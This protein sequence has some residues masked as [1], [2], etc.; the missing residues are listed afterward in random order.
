[1]FPVSV[2]ISSPSLINLMHATMKST[3]NTNNKLN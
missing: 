1:M 3:N 2:N